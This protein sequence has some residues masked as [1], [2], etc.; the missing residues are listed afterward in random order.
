MNPFF[1]WL[2]GLLQKR[3]SHPGDVVKA[4]VLEGDGD[5]HRVLWCEVCGAYDVRRA[6]A[7]NRLVYEMRRPRPDWHTPKERSRLRDALRISEER[8]R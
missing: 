3:C 5:N 8:A 4:A 6:G 2:L 7:T 1:L